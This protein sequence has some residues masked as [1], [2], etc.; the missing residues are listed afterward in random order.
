MTGIPLNKI[1]LQKYTGDTRGKKVAVLVECRNDHPRLSLVIQEARKA[2]PSDWKIQVFHGNQ[3]QIS[4]EE[5]VDYTTPIGVDNLDILA[6]NTLMTSPEFW[7]ACCGEHILIFQ[8]DVYFCR[9]T[10]VKSFDSYLEYDY[11]GSPYNWYEK[12]YIALRFNTGQSELANGGVSLRRR[13]AMIKV[14]Q[15]HP[16]DHYTP[17]D[18][19]FC[20]HVP[21][22]CPADLASIVFN[23][24]KPTLSKN[25]VP[26]A[27]HK[28]TSIIPTV[29][30]DCAKNIGE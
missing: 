23:D 22:V 8:T 20:K 11:V 27:I 1:L 10:T 19:Y 28:N 9:N 18:I 16:W 24:S 21:R 12:L 15:D 4:E 25:H 3:I 13:S 6:Y 30:C 14:C 26:W 7:K 2:L 17:E 5:P 29:G